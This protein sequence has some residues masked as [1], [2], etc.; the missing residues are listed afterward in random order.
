MAEKGST[1]RKGL[2]VLLGKVLG[3]K[4]VV[5]MHTGP[6]MNWYKSLSV[7]NKRIVK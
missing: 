2:I 1:Y 7:I 3:V 4:V 6:I 5:Q